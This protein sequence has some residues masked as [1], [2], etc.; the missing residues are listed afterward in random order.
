VRPKTPE[1]LVLVWRL[2]TGGSSDRVWMWRTLRRLGAA[3]LTPGAAALPYS[4]EVQEQL[5]WLAQEVDQH[6]GDAW[7]LPVV[8]LSGD[9]ARRIREQSNADR[10]A[11]YASLL[12]GATSFLE[13]AGRLPGVEG[14][15]GD[16]L[17]TDKELLA[18]QRRFQKITARDHFSAPGR[19]RTAAAID[20]CLTFRQGISRKLLPVTDPHPDAKE[21]R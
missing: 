7:V 9:E 20:R 11:E 15:F 16:R 3:S 10:G 17:R 1:W 8:E 12:D 5:D 14:E 19:R 21:E 6:G 4:E 2:P 13:R 18:L